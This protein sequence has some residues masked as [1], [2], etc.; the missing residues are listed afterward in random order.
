[1][2]NRNTGFIVGIAI[3][4][5]IGAALDNI[6]IGA[7]IGAALGVAFAGIGCKK[8]ITTEQVERENQ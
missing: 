1:M 5:A 4:I 6:A 2:K 3:G 7:G 8:E